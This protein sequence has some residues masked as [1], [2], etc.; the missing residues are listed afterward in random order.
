ME[1]TKE[2]KSYYKEAL[3]NPFDYNKNE[4]L[5]TDYEKSP[6][7][8]N[9]EELKDRWRKQ[10]KLSTLASLTDKLDFEKNKDS[11]SKTN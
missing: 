9:K 7:T 1:R 2:S 10:I 6:Y 5:D 3:A 8:K 4:E 11:I